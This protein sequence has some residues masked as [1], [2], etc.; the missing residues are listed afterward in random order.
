MLP[1]EAEIGE[2]GILADK[3]ILD[4]G[5]IRRDNIDRA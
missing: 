4:A 5:E 2:G 3:G 1:A